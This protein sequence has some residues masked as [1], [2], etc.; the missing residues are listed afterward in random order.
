MD[1]NVTREIR[2]EHNGSIHKF[3]FGV[4]A[5]NVETDADHRFI[6]DDEK[7]HIKETKEKIEKIE[8]EWQE[9]LEHDHDD[10][11]YRIGAINE[12][13]IVFKYNHAVRW[14][15]SAYIQSNRPQELTLA[16]S[17]E[18]EYKILYG[19]RDGSWAFAPN[20]SGMLQLGTA[21][22]GWAG[23]YS[24]GGFNSVSDRRLK[25]D[26][27]KPDDYDIEGFVK[28]LQVLFFRYTYD[29]SRTYCGLMAQDVEALIKKYRL[30]E[31]FALLTKTPVYNRKKEI[32]DYSY[33]VDY[34]QLAGLLIHVFQMHLKKDECV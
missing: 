17:Q 27:R 31:D 2:Q 3:P 8:R 10:R 1:K 22:Y 12:N 21:E 15:N 33:S 6:S 11:Y 28:E 29:S 16:P 20:A 13:D 30:P 23:V 24:T 19:I 26:F 9:S 18:D 25:T 32:V 5:E 4:L 34:T 7:K 14:E